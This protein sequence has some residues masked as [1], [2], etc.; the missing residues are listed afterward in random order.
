MEVY[1]KVILKMGY[2]MEK[3][4]LNGYIK[5]KNMKEIIFLGK[6]MGKE[7]FGLKMGIFLKEIFLM[8]KFMVMENMNLKEMLLNVFGEM[9]KL[10]KNHF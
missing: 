1:I 8:V 10:L 9:V 7:N 2:I 6:K 5:M 3:E 4:F